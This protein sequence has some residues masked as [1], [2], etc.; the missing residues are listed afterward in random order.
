MSK[1]LQLYPVPLRAPVIAAGGV[2]TLAF[3]A[4]PTRVFSRIAHLAGLLFR[5]R[6]TPA[7]TTAPTV[8]GLHNLVAGLQF[9]DGDNLRFNGSL[10]SMRQHELLENGQLKSADP[11]TNSGSGNGFY[12]ERYLPM[13]LDSWAGKQSDWLV[14]VAQLRNAA[15][16]MNFGALAQISADCTAFTAAIEVSAVL[17]FLDNEIRSAP[18]VERNSFAVASNDQVVQGRAL[19]AHLGLQAGNLTT[20]TALVAGNVGNVSIDTGAG[21]TP[22]VSAQTLTALARASLRSGKISE[23]QGEP[24][25]AT[26]DNTKEVNSGTPTAL[27]SPAAS[28]QPIITSAPESRITKAWA[29]TQT[30]LRVKWSGNLT[31]GLLHSCRLLPQSDSARAAAM[32]KALAELRLQSQGTKSKTLSK[33]PYLGARSEYMPTATKV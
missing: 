11:D 20:V 5:C 13:G 6:I 15:L 14:P 26:D 30:G 4:L 12:F 22:S 27:Q 28:V 17:A 21:S 31:S 23:L 33:Q 7:F 2:D 18:V 10:N 16:Q 32:G 19:Y 25:A 1:G 3:D 9:N 24:A 8:A 29:E